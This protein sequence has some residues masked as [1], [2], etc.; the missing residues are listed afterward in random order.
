MRCK[1]GKPKLRAR[2]ACREAVN[3]MREQYRAQI[4]KS[5]SPEPPKEE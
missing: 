4:S 5:Q 3:S 1:N 2:R